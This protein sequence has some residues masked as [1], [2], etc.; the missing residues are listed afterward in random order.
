MFPNT[1][2]YFSLRAV[3]VNQNRNLVNPECSSAWVSI[4][5][6]TSLIDSPA[7]LET[8]NDGELGFYWTDAGHPE[9]TADDYNICA[10][11]PG[12]ADYVLMS[13]SQS[14]IVKDKDGTY[15]GRILGLKT[16]TSYNI[17][18]LRGVAADGTSAT[19]YVKSG[20]QTRDSYHQ[21]EIKWQGA[22]VNDYPY[23]AYEIAI[24][25][26]DASDY[27][28]LDASDLEQY[29]DADGKVLPYYT[30]ETA[31][32]LA[33]NNTEYFYT[34]IM[35]EKVVLPGGLVTHQPLR[36]NIKY[37]IKVRAVEV[38]AADTSVISYS[39]YIGPVN[40]RTDFSQQDYDN[41]DTENE[42]QAVFLD[43]MNALEQGY[44]W[45]VSISDSTASRILLKGDKV[46]GAMESLPGGEFTVDMT[47][48]PA[49]GGFYEIYVPVSVIKAMNTYNKSLVI[50][51]KEISFTLNVRNP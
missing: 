6:T 9:L 17:K 13:R 41:T 4:P 27:T 33:S 19:V 47:T 38:D 11:G 30:E 1:L 39:K 12:D 44:Y 16:D 7:A 15:Y 34:R 31:Q 10:E 20:L 35:T 37:Y 18:V 29:T 43:R 36:S 5:V 42:Q 23:S 14:T 46:T 3:R 26:E 24:R 40:M 50:Q 51:T 28:T 22:P 2:Y 49:D 45:R 48:I 25:A 8:V 32:T 21:I